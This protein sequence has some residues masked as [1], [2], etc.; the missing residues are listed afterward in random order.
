MRIAEVQTI[1]ER[2]IKLARCKNCTKKGGW[3]LAQFIFS[4]VISPP[5]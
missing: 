4:Y 2:R 1:D 5:G 3:M